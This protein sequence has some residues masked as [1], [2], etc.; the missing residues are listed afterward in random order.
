M[1]TKPKI[2]IDLAKVTQRASEGKT[3][4]QMA[5]ALGVSDD[6]IYSR[7]RESKEFREAIKKGQEMS[8]EVVENTLFN[9]AKS[10][11]CVAATIYW[12]K[13]RCRERWSDKQQIDLSSSGPIQIQIINDLKD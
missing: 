13:C 4:A 3:V 7:K 5:A 8:N 6:T 9:M 1:I 10:G 12:L 2:E 11:E